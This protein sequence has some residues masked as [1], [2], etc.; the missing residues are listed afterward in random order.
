MTFIL[1]VRD[2]EEEEEKEEEGDEGYFLLKLCLVRPW[3]LHL[4]QELYA[5]FST[6]RT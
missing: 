6:S 5:L 1:D 4:Y 2:V 3:E